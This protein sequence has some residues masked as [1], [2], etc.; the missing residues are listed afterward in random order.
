MPE[1]CAVISMDDVQARHQDHG[2]KEY[3]RTTE[4]NNDTE[5]PC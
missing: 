2:Y 4:I 5:Y 3:I 1:F